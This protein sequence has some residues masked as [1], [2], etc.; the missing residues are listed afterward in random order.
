MWRDGLSKGPDGV[1]RQIPQRAVW[2]SGVWITKEGRARRRWYNLSTRKWSWDED[3]LPYV[4]RENRVGLHLDGWISIERALALAWRKRAP[5]SSSR[6]L[7]FEPL[8]KDNVRWMEEETD[9]GKGSDGG[10]ETWRPLRWYC[11]AVRCDTRYEISNKGRLRSP[12]SGEV[13]GGFWFADRRFAAV[14][15]AGLVDITSASGFGR[16]PVPL[17]L[18][19]A[20]DALLAGAHP[21][22]LAAAALVQES[23]AWCYFSRAAQQLALCD[24]QRLIPPLI[25]KRLWKALLA[26][27]GTPVLGASLKE[28]AQALPFEVPFEQLRLARLVLAR[29]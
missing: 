14:K 15:G 29:S 28:L 18:A 22:D 6:V 24:L 19:Q 8:S 16:E 21:R 10:R 4:F 9:E 20:V 7:A 2:T 13:T 12:H 26:L 3:P 27:R 23:T 25:S 1:C 11:G 17:Y 5:D